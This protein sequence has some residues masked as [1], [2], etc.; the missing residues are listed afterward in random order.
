MPAYQFSEGEQWRQLDFMNNGFVSVV[1]VNINR[2]SL[3]RL[4]RREM[5][6][7]LQMEPP[8]TP[9]MEQLQEKA[10]RLEANYDLLDG[11]AEPPQGKLWLRVCCKGPGLRTAEEARQA[12]VDVE[13]L[14]RN[15]KSTKKARLTLMWAM[16]QRFDEL[17]GAASGSGLGPASSA[18][19]A[20]AA[21]SA[22][23]GEGPLAEPGTGSGSADPACGRSLDDLEEEAE[24]L[25]DEEA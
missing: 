20:S 4:L 15:S 5:D 8:L 16:D 24:A 19:S 10:R 22:A 6:A 21:S 12:K 9:E 14:L 2:M 17:E 25:E 23:A 18:A 11:P 1:E 7:V 3:L 13:A